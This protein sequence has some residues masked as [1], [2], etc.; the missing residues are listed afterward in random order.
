MVSVLGPVSFR[1]S[2][3]EY[4]S[5]TDTGILQQIFADNSHIA[6]SDVIDAIKDEFLSRTESYIALNG[7]FTELPGARKLLQRLAGSSNHQVA[8]ATGG[9]KATAELKLSTA[10]FDVIGL[11]LATSDDAV[12]RT[13]IMEIAL[14]RIGQ[15][16]DAITYFGDGEWDR[17]ACDRLGWSFVAVGSALGGIES[18]HEA[19]I[20]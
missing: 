10:G 12:E 4:D 3:R 13:E 5:I 1:K 19:I 2:L 6:D 15:K 9:W 8:I 11:P 7:P 18:Y 16:T 14:A 17:A 20:E